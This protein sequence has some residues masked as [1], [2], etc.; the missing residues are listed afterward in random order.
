M[1]YEL[2]VHDHGHMNSPNAEC[3]WQPI[4]DKGIKSTA[5]VSYCYLCKLHVN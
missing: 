5:C 2:L 3:L 1:F 4:A